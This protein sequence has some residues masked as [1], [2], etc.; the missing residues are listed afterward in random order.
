MASGIDKIFANRVIH[1]GFE[2][3]LQQYM[4]RKL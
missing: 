4:L 1:A 3:Q 2:L